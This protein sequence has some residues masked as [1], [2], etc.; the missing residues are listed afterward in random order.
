MQRSL[1]DLTEVG[2]NSCARDSWKGLDRELAWRKEEAK[3]F[4]GHSRKRG[5]PEHLLSQ[6]H[7]FR[8]VGARIKAGSR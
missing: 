2:G 3:K 8:K 6:A 7:L 4:H 1:P 5:T